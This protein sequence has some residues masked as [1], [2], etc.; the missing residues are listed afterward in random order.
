MGSM[1][2]LFHESVYSRVARLKNEAVP[3]ALFTLALASATSRLADCL[4]SCAIRFRAQFVGL[5]NEDLPV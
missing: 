5:Q 4:T 2:G 3:L 1:F